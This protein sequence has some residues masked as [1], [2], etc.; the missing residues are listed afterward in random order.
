MSNVLVSRERFSSAVFVV[1]VTC[2]GCVD[3]KVDRH[4]YI[5]HDRAIEKNDQ[6]KTAPHQLHCLNCLT[7]THTSNVRLSNIKRLI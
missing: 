2:S 4:S 6:N 5:D 1:V 7:L 3:F